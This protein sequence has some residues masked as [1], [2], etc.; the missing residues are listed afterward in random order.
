MRGISLYRVWAII[1]KEFVLM[2]RDP[3]LILIMAVMPLILVWITGYAVNIHPE[4]VPSVIVNYD[5]T[6]FTQEIIRKMENTKYVSFVYSTTDSEKAYKMIRQNKAYIAVTIPA[7]FSRDFYRGQEPA[8]LVEDGSIDSFSTNRAIIAI[9]GVRDSML[10]DLLLKK[11]VSPDKS[12]SFNIINH[13]IYDPEQN[14][15]IYTVPGMIGLVLMLTM[16]MITVAISF[17]DIQGG[18]I[19]YLLVSPIKASEIFLGEIISYVLVGYVQ[20]TFGLLIAHFIFDISFLGHVGL[21][22]ICVLPYIVAEL[23]LGIT[24]CTFCSSQFQAVQVI[25]AFIALSVILSGFIFPIFGMPDWAQVISLFLPLTYFFKILYGIM[26]RDSS[27][28]EVW[29]HLWPL[30]VYSL[31]MLTLASYRFSYH[32][33]KT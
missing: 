29:Q 4:K 12:N 21:L 2:K 24:I 17:R 5:N 16:L 10:Q 25:N 9:S 30:I 15:H 31:L 28:I 32:N 6:P 33:R 7:N 13:R 26:L 14:T 1:R 19:E 18:S 27:F 3:A 22:Y 23:V 8:I 11:N 20:F